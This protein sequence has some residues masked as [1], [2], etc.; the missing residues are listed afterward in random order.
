MSFLNLDII[1]YLCEFITDTKFIF[2]NKDFYEHRFIIM[3]NKIKRYEM[4][5][6]CLYI[7]DYNSLYNILKTIII[8]DIKIERDQ[9]NY[10][11]ITNS[12][13]CPG[14]IYANNYIVICP[15][16]ISMPN[17]CFE[18]ILIDYVLLKLNVCIWPIDAYFKANYIIFKETKM[19]YEDILDGEKYGY[20]YECSYS[21]REPVYHENYYKIIDYLNFIDEHS[22]DFVERMLYTIDISSLL[23]K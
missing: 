14:I 10:W 6:Y 19:A 16:F 17:K 20:C 18:D 5:D 9:I 4:T 11:D 22:Y 21:Y 23:L 1:G 13:F 2:I 15:L 3:K 7:K 12:N 8:H